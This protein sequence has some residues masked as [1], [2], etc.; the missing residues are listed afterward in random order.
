[1][2]IPIYTPLYTH[3]TK[4]NVEREKEEAGE[5]EEEEKENMKEEQKR[6]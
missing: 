6:T 5:G 2:Y 3:P 4:G 1:L